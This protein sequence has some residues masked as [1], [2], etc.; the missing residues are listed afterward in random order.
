[1]AAGA[2]K[3]AGPNECS[4][5]AGEGGCWGRRGPP[6]LELLYRLEQAAGRGR[7][8]A[9]TLPQRA[10]PRRR[11]RPQGGPR[12]AT[13]GLGAPGRGVAV[14]VS[15]LGGT[16]G[17]DVVDSSRALTLRTKG[18]GAGAGPG[19][20]QRGPAR[21]CG[22]GRRAPRARRSRVLGAES[23]G[24]RSVPAVGEGLARALHVR[25]GRRAGRR[26]GAQPTASS[27]VRRSRGLGAT[28]TGGRAPLRATGGPRAPPPVQV[29]R[30]PSAALG[31][32]C[33]RTQLARGAVGCRRGG[34]PRA[35]G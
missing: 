9:A 21:A 13:R 29:R 4:C 34:G 15:D 18:R 12:D 3:R 28:E 10:P 27:L 25:K 35:G 1:M 11:A 26:C 24:G 8:G 22:R 20:S 5:A 33:A 16:S 30:A 23:G 31:P 6:A 19:G 14:A 2:A 32:S 7:R 17:S